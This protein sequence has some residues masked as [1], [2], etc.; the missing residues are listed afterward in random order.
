MK[1]GEVVVSMGS[2]DY[3]PLVALS[4]KNTFECALIFNNIVEVHGH[5]THVTEILKRNFGI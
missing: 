5:C 1:L 3:S 2:F 4:N